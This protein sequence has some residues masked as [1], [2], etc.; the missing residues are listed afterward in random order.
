[1]QTAT[2][3]PLAHAPGESPFRI[4]GLAYRSLMRDVERRVP[5]GV[6][7]LVAGL[8]DPQLQRFVAQPFL[9]ASWYD[10]LPMTELAAHIAKE[11]GLSP[12][13]Y[14]RELSRAQAAED[15][16]GVYRTL[17]AVVSPRL[18]VNRLPRLTQ[19]YF[20]WGEIHTEALGSSRMR[21][22]RTQVPVCLTDWYAA[23]SSPYVAYSMQKAGAASPRFELVHAKAAASLHGV[24][25]RTLVFEASWA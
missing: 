22:L 24:P 3:T 11:L 23:V 2:A 10:V 5:G 1:M 13:E 6:A 9:A 15:L 21:V 16:V 4:K 12:D 18:V 17:L 19:R 25:T 14:T 7:G 20:S 8:R